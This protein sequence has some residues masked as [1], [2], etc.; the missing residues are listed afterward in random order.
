MKR[1]L[2]TLLTVAL[3]AALAAFV[4]APGVVRQI[5]LRENAQAASGYRAATDGLSPL[6]CGTLLAQAQDH[7][8]ALASAPWAD[9]FAE[10]PE[11]PADGYEA[12][13]NPAGDG[14][15]AVL[16]IPKL[17]VTLAVY[18]G[19]GAEASP[20][21]VA[22]APWSRLPSGDT[23]GPCVLYAGRERLFDPLAGLNRLIAGDCFFL[24]VL[25]GTATYEVFQ[26][27]RLDPGA[28]GTLE[29]VGDEDECA[30][31]A[32]T[33]AGQR[34]VVRARRVPRQS[35]KPVDDSAALPGGIPELM[36]AAPVAVAGLALMT[37]I[38]WIRRAARRHRRRHTRL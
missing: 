13:L 5:R 23:D 26:V 19:G 4:A 9:P 15:M 25:Q 16:E 27:A 11:P 18:H 35:V 28:L 10:A 36:L 8:S 31:V 24:R 14:V 22:H 21:R 38:E 2:L 1:F 17:G 29:R 32:V 3:V 12:L 34:L 20:A 37:V 33:D 6:D 30:L 7:N